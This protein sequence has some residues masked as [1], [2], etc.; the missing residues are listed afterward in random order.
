MIDLIKPSYDRIGDLE[1]VQVKE[2]IR[3][4]ACNLDINGCTF[5]TFAKISEKTVSE[6]CIIVKYA[7]PS[8]YRGIQLLPKFVDIDITQR[9]LRSLSCSRDIDF[10]T[11]L[12]DLIY[13]VS[14]E[15]FIPDIIRS[16]AKS[17]I[18]KKII[19]EILYEDFPRVVNHTG[20]ENLL[21]VFEEITTEFELKMVNSLNLFNQYFFCSAII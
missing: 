9:L 4:L 11:D 15:I 20:I 18:G 5:G 21:S 7:D 17:R 19:L 8:D 3:T 13:D 1:S 14:F 12:F 10:L 16:S 2:L 6:G